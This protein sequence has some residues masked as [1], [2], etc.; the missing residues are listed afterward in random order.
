MSVRRA[1]TA[2]L[3]AVATAGA[4][5]WVLHDGDAGAAMAPVRVAVGLDA[6]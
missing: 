1:V 3:V 2:C 5:L 4:C 6:R